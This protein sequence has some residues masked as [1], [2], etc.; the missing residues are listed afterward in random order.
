MNTIHCPSIP[1]TSSNEFAHKC[2]TLV[3]FSYNEVEKYCAE[4]YYSSNPSLC[5][6]SIE[7]IPKRHIQGD[8]DI[9]K[10][11]S[12]LV[13]DLSSFSSYFTDNGIN[14]W[15]LMVGNINSCSTINNAL[16]S[17]IMT[18]LVKPPPTFEVNSW[19]KTRECL[20]ILKLNDQM[21]DTRTSNT[22]EKSEIPHNKLTE[23]NKQLY[24]M[25]KPQSPDVCSK[26]GKTPIKR[27]CQ[28][29]F[30]TS[31]PLDTRPSISG[32]Q[33]YKRISVLGRKRKLLPHED[34]TDDLLTGV[35]PICSS[36]PHSQLVHSQ[37]ELAVAADDLPD[38]QPLDS[39]NED[40]IDSSQP[41][42]ETNEFIVKK[43]KRKRNK[44]SPDSSGQCSN[45]SDRL[46]WPGTLERRESSLRKLLLD[47]QLRRHYQLSPQL[48]SNTVSQ[49]L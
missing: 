46:E 2:Y 47:S 11:Q 40:F 29:T 8:F 6:S 31:T 12:G 42:R 44:S 27:T 22:A 25:Q 20:L 30:M 37:E 45:T 39:S 13:S 49:L 16:K 10:P 34:Q 43:R 5:Y 35:E 26:T 41:S 36:A 19:L 3:P 17:I 24:I 48:S 7:D 28:S 33:E 38:T 21:K 23:V 18:P 14:H 15:G 32:R 1:N 4:E 9:T